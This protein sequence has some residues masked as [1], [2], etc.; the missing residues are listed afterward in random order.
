MR[1][2]GK[3]QEHLT[4]VNNT[5]QTYTGIIIT[6]HNRIIFKKDLIMWIDVSSRRHSNYCYIFMDN[7]SVRELNVSVFDDRQC[8]INSFVEWNYFEHWWP[9]SIFAFVYLNFRLIN[10]YKKTLDKKNINL[11]PIICWTWIFHFFGTSVDK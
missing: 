1:L 9:T 5:Q 10:Q 6:T 8:S 11:L 4:K 7:I 2:H 3:L